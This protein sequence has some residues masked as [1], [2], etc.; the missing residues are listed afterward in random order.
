TVIAVISLLMAIILPSMSSARALSKLTVCLSNLREVGAAI[1]TYSLNNEGSIPHGPSTPSAY[2]AGNWDDW[3]TNQLWIGANSQYN[4]LGPVLVQ[5]LKQPKI[6]YCP[7]DN[8]DDPIEELAKLENL[9]NQDIYASYLYRQRAQTTREKFD[10][11]GF[12]AAN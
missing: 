2:G 9:G 6:L 8:S 1:K 3:P 12:N 5:E 10:D 11:L 7:G 4:G